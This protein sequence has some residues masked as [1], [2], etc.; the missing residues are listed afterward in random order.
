MGITG[1]VTIASLPL[2]PTAGVGSS[3]GVGSVSEEVVDFFKEFDKRTPNPHPEWHFWKFNGPL[4]SYGDFWVLSDSM[5]YLQQLTTKY[6]NFITKF[7]LGAG[8]GGP[9]LS[10]LSS[11]LA[12]MSKFDLGSVTKVQ[13]LAWRSVVQDLMEVGFDIG[14]MIGHLWQIPQHLFGRKISDEMQVLQHQIAF[15]QDSLAV[16]T[17]YHE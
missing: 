7:K 17:T 1:E 9:M 3:V 10:L 16:L 11:V 2:R 4:V 5:P 8:L 14:F 6:G 15:L 12:A 13:I